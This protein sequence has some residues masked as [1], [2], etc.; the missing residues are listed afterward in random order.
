MSRACGDKTIG[1]VQAVSVV[2]SDLITRVLDE[3]D[4]ASEADVKTEGKKACLRGHAFRVGAI[5][6][7]THPAS[8]KSR[9]VSAHGRCLGKDWLALVAQ[10]RLTTDEVCSIELPTTGGTTH[11]LR[12]RVEHG[13]RHQQGMQA[14]DVL[15]RFER[16][17]DLVRYVS[18]LW[19]ARVLVADDSKTVCCLMR[20]M[21]AERQADAMCVLNGRKALGAAR[22]ERFD[23]ILLDVEMPEMTGIEA[24]HTLREEGYLW[25]IVMVTSVRGE[26]SRYA[27][28]EAGCDAF[29]SKPPNENDIAG[30]VLR[31]KPPPLVSTFAED[32]RSFELIDEF[33]A[34]ARASATRM[35][36]AFKSNDTAA[37]ESTA[38]QIRSAAP[39]CGFAEMAM[40]AERVEHTIEA[41][42]PRSDLRRPVVLL[43]QQCMAARPATNFDKP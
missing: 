7:K 37:L 27:S 31:M 17:L 16:D 26:D 32:P 12:G 24:A 41:G 11:V 19:R 34:E 14:W 38:R 4:A 10:E 39:A 13:R 9:V 42:F 35:E 40:L 3:L 33:V 6:V 21:L 25:P 23:L 36:T 5:S 43:A 18:D 1:A 2:S 29:I 28:M 22:Q 20:K 15:V 8:G 30:L